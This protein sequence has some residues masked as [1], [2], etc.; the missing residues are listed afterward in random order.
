[1]N[2][3]VWVPYPRSRNVTVL[4]Q[5]KPTF[6]V[7]PSNILRRHS[8]LAVQHHRHIDGT[9]PR[10]HEHKS[11]LVFA[12]TSIDL[13][14]DLGATSSLSLSF[15][16]E[17]VSQKIVF[18]CITRNLYGWNMKE[19][20][21]FHP[22]SQ[23]MISFQA[24]QSSNCQGMLGPAGIVPIFLLVKTFKSASWSKIRRMRRSYEIIF[25]ATKQIRR[26]TFCAKAHGFSSPTT[27]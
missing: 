8:H 12:T 27:S 17:F 4:G 18:M 25:G 11:N 7:K 9:A 20:L 14:N 22:L 23:E 5:S 1:M 10:W 2:A 26:N 6:V 19:P 24:A 16:R 3:N 21:W 13:L 15:H